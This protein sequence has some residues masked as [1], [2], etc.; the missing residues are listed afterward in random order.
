LLS[1]LAPEATQRLG[2]YL[3]EGGLDNA[4]EAL[5]Y[6]AFLLGRD[7]AWLE[8][9]L[10][11]PRLHHLHHATDPDAIDKNFAVHLPILDRLFGTLFAPKGRWPT[12]TGVVGFRAPTPA[13]APKSAATPAK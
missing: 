2:R 12:R 9:V 11:T 3:A 5:R 1:T 4:R 8:P 10:M 7:V 13:I 6:A